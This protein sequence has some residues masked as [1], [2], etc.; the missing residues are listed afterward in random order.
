[1]D[2]NRPRPSAAAN[3][4]CRFQAIL[5]D[6]DG[7]LLDTIDDLRD[8]MNLVLRQMGHATHPREAYKY[9]VGNGMEVLAKRAL[10]AAARDQP[11][12]ARCVALMREEYGRRWRQRT[13]PYEGISELL[14]TLRGLGMRLAVLSN[15]PHDLT[16]ATVEHFFPDRPFTIVRGA[17]DDVPKKPDPTGALQVAK[18]LGIAPPATLYLGDTSIDMQT[19][20][21]AAMYPVGAA[22]GFR[23]P[24]ELQASGAAAIIG[25]PLELVGLAEQMTCIPD[26]PHESQKNRSADGDPQ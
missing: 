8:A 6:L 9:F 7:T 17:K 1:M 14:T 5:F 15:K 26:E 23:T 25:H 11:T 10:P 4:G 24:E 2:T 3:G 18:L 19:A 13:R 12:V 16:L 20:R 21:A 22:W